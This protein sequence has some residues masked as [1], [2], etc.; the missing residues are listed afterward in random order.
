MG[1]VDVTVSGRVVSQVIVCPPS[2]GSYPS[3]MI[4]TSLLILSLAGAG[5]TTELRW[6]EQE[7]LALF[8]SLSVR[9]VVE[10]GEATVGGAAFHLRSVEP[11][12][13]GES[14]PVFLRATLTL[15]GEPSELS[16]WAE[17]SKRLDEADPDI[18]LSYSWDL[19]TA[20][21]AHVVHLQADCTFSEESFLTVARA[22]AERLPGVR[23]S[24]WCEC[25]AGCRP[26][27]PS[28]KEVPRLPA[29]RRDPEGEEGDYDD[30]F[31]PSGTW[32]SPIGELS[33]MHHADT[34]S[35]YYTAVFGETAHVCEGASVAGLVG[36][37]R[38]EQPDAQ[39]TVAFTIT[40]RGIR[41]ELVDGIASFCGAG[42]A[43]D[44]FVLED[45]RPPSTCEV[46]VERSAF[47]V[48][49]LAEPEARPAHV[50]RGDRVEVVPAWPADGEEWVLARF[51]GPSS[52]TVGLLPGA[53][54]ACSEEERDL[55]D[56]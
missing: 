12:E 45:Y 50:T 5:A 34:L 11:I 30:R 49:D 33:L 39:G 43:G 54:L 41:L 18:G 31:D 53:D 47:H 36:R 27:F 32:S 19:V 56:R 46:I 17:V 55:H 14:G 23:R 8:E 3:Y 21:G 29:V 26:G 10:H 37:D 38:Y 1:G 22:L 6:N 16:A 4:G 2:R 35:F 25:G 13:R 24:F 44:R 42:W 52:T 40:E 51:V 9:F 28:L 7:A 15:S 48:V 20:V